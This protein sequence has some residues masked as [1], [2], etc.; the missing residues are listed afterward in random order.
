MA[1]PISEAAELHR[2][3]RFDRLSRVGFAE[4]VL[5]G[6][7]RQL[8]LG[9]RGIEGGFQLGPE[10]FPLPF[11]LEGVVEH[12]ERALGKVVGH[13]LEAAGEETRQD[14]GEAGREQGVV[15]R[16]GLQFV[17]Q[18]AQLPGGRLDRVGGGAHRRDGCLAAGVV[19]DDLAGGTERYPGEL[20]DR[21]LRLGVEGTQALDLVA[22]EF[23][24]DRR[25]VE[26]RPDVEDAA[27][28]RESSR[29]L[30][31]RHLG[32]PGGGELVRKLVPVLGDP[33]GEL[34]A[35]LI[36]RLARQHP[37]GQPPHRVAQMQVEEPGDPRHG[38]A[39]I[40]GQSLVGQHFVPGKADDGGA[41]RLGGE[42]AQVLFQG[43]GRIV[44]GND[45]DEGQLQ[46]P[47]Q[48][49]QG[50]A[51][52]GADQAMSAHFAGAAPN[53]VEELGQRRS[54]RAALLGEG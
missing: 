47:R 32:V 28:H 35:S 6:R 11:Q 44:G 43:F 12:P 19:E 41:R 23:D 42:E 14:G 36:E 15:L 48:L 24:A 51:P 31:E 37:A 38:D 25:L 54:V 1:N 30:D 8:T 17:D 26:R 27:A 20:R 13:R 4:V 21:A 29:V 40:G 52:G 3:G 45:A 9:P 7:E 2:A 5:L 33:C 16:A 53:G 49:P 39:G 22:E 50:M 10:I 34:Q 18:L 46:L